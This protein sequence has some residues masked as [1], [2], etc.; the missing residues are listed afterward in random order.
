MPCRALE[1]ACVHAC[2]CVCYITCFLLGKKIFLV[3]VN[4]V[5]TQLENA[6]SRRNTL[7][8]K[9]EICKENQ[10]VKYQLKGF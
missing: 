1:R 9:N 5:I 7:Q 8:D 10:A 6:K 3:N 4:G 2:R